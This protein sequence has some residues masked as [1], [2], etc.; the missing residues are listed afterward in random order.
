MLGSQIDKKK[1]FK[2]KKLS[3]KLFLCSEIIKKKRQ[4][5]VYSDGRMKY[6]HS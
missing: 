5:F 2:V 4:V 3:S 6:C 1:R